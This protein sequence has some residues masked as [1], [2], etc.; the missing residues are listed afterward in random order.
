MEERQQ[1]RRRRC[2]IHHVL[3]EGPERTTTF[4]TKVSTSSKRDGRT[5]GEVTCQIKTEGVQA[6]WQGPSIRRRP[7]PHARSCDEAVETQRSHSQH[8][9]PRCIIRGHRITRTTVHSQQ[10]ATEATTSSPYNYSPQRCYSTETTPG[11]RRSS[12]GGR[13]CIHP[14]STHRTTEGRKE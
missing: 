14:P 11:R 10:T 1:G 8:P 4:L 7:S 12:R 5:K 6:R 3:Q 2:P 9:R 13:H